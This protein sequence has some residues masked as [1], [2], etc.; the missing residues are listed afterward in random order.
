MWM[1][2]AFFVVDDFGGGSAFT[3]DHLPFSFAC[4]RPSRYA[5]LK[6]LDSPKQ[7][8]SIFQ[9]RAASS[10]GSRAEVERSETPLDALELAKTI[11]PRFCV[12]GTDSK[13]GPKRLGGGEDKRGFVGCIHLR[14]HHF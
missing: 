9:V 14:M 11:E 7:A 6:N 5:A 13:T 3:K 4:L 12:N 8:A 10:S 2:K 1:P